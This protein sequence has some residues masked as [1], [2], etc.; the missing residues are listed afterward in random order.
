MQYLLERRKKLGGLI[1]KRTVKNKPIEAPDEKIFKSYVEGSGDRQ[2]ATTMVAVQLLAKLLKDK[3]IGKLIVP[4]VPDE[5]RTFG[6][7]AL[8]GR[9]GIY[10][11]I[12]QQYEP[13]DKG[14]LLYYKES[15]TGAILEE[16]ITEAG[17]ICSFIAAGT[18]YATHG[19][20]TIPFYFFYSMFGFQRTGDFIWAAA[21]ARARGFLIGGTS[22]RTTLPGEGLQHQDG[23]NHAFAFAYPNVKAY[24]PA[25]AYEVATI[26]QDGIRRMYVEQED[27]FYYITVMNDTYQMPP[28]P[29]GVEEGILKGMYRYQT[30]KKKKKDKVHLLGS[31]A[32]MLEVIKAAAIL[33]DDYGIAVDIWSVTSY[34]SLYDDAIAVDRLNR[35]HTNKKTQQNYIEQCFSGEEG[36]IVAASDYLKLL[37]LSI[38]KWFPDTLHVLGTD[39]FGRSESRD[40]LRDFFEVDH[41]YIIL[42]ALSALKDKGKV[43]AKTLNDAIKKLKIDPDKDNPTSY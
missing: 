8:F 33:E 17:S 5:S 25:F 12:G 13:V 14:S 32:I 18:A 43:K 9:V 36:P 23:H 37:P 11:P 2:V 24:D 26:V 10:S 19:I 34:K 3:N 40:M 30:S 29:K 41:R 31:G 28:M 4:I 21:D 7:D 15:K 39:G 20:N 27:I 6:M 42:A 35:L 38:A 1:P 16:G 22:G